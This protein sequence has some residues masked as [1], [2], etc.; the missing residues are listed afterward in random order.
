MKS[1][2]ENTYFHGKSKRQT[3]KHS[4]MGQKVM[5][6]PPTVLTEWV[7]SIA[8]NLILGPFTQKCRQ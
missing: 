4:E 2:T 1:N 5:K 6:A 8:I 7:D 3:Q